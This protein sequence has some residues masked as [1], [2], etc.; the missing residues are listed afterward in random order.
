MFLPG[1]IIDA[2]HI[3]TE[4]GALKGNAPLDCTVG[5]IVDVLMRPDDIVHDDTSLQQATV[6]QKAFKGAEILYTLQLT[7]GSKVLS[8]VPSHHNHGLGEKIGIK[9]VAD[10]IVTFKQ[11]T[12]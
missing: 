10:H 3:E 6:I 11:K 8:L 1:K 12:G 5:S 2:H 7:S 4:L 9:V